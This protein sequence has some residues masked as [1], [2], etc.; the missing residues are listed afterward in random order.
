MRAVYCNTRTIRQVFAASALAVAAGASSGQTLTWIGPPAGGDWNTP[1]NWSPFGVPDTLAEAAVIAQPGFDIVVNDIGVGSLTL[2]DPTGSLEVRGTCDLWGPLMNDGVLTVDTGASFEVHATTDFTGSG[3]L[4]LN[5][6]MNDGVLPHLIPIL[7]SD[8]GV[9]VTNGPSHTI[10]G[11]GIIER[12]LLN[13]GTVHAGAVG[14]GLRFQEGPVV[15]EGVIRV[16][17]QSWIELGAV[18][19]DNTLGTVIVDG[20]TLRTIGLGGTV[21][22]GGQIIAENGGIIRVSNRSGVSFQGGVVLEGT[23]EQETNSAVSVVDG[24]LVNNGTYILTAGALF[25]P[26]VAGAGG[27]E[28]I[29]AG[30]GELILDGSPQFLEIAGDGRLVNGPGHT[31]RGGG[32]LRGIINRGVILADRPGQLV[33]WEAFTPEPNSGVLGAAN[34]GRFE[35]TGDI[36]QSPTGRIENRG[37]DV[38]VG[39]NRTPNIIGGTLAGTNGPIRVGY[40]TDLVARNV[41]IEGDIEV[42]LGAELRVA[43]GDGVTPSGFTNNGRIWALNDRV[44]DA[45]VRF[46]ESGTIDGV[47]EIVL[48]DPV[49]DG[50]QGRIKANK[51]LTI[52]GTLGAGQSIVGDGYLDGTLNLNGTLSPGYETGDLTRVISIA[53]A[54]NL[55][56]T[57]RLVV[58]VQGA[59]LSGFDRLVGEG[60][61]ALGG[62]LELRIAPSFA[63]VEGASLEIVAVASRVGR[64]NT[65]IAP[66]LPGGLAWRVRYGPGSVIVEIGAACPADVTTDGTSN[67]I[68]D[69][70]VT[71][72]DFSFYLG[73]WGASDPAADVTTDG[74][75]NG[76]PDGSVTL[77]DF[78]FYLALWG[79]GCP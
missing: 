9:T 16:D 29:I 23:L 62:S 6:P 75:A 13:R 56:T 15:N 46:Y 34:G 1:T 10:A 28:S 36:E 64:F 14:E 66:E 49:D 25:S 50:V 78:S 26:G 69:G 12:S 68:P 79:A 5:G 47:G 41:T 8:P 11:S 53:D 74:T 70:A 20:G 57:H 59:W 22:R 52:E 7:A 24:G 48:G 37:G 44:E 72:S 27:A 38:F 55:G 17:P 35:I 31:M 2:G 63:Q 32:L 54:V 43:E 60:S 45:P 19:L 33:R 77:S 40:N 61:I 51:P 58:D 67:G 73:L 76:I 39:Q 71:L 30:T 21:V 18:A 42:S 4:R 3:V 65:L